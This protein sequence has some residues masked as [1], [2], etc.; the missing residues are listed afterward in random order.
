VAIWFSEAG[1]DLDAVVVSFCLSLERMRKAYGHEE[2][3]GEK[4]EN[5][6]VDQAD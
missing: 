4:G 1:M 6:Q 3:E 5:D 2:R